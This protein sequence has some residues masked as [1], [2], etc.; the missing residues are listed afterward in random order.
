[1]LVLLAELYSI[2]S[3]VFSCTGV[4]YYSD[5]IDSLVAANITPMVTM[6]HWDLPQALEDLGGWNNDS[7][8]DIFVDYARLLFDEYGDRV[9]NRF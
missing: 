9:N 5:L 4:A 1:M 6:N 2:V 8:V 3:W 7:I